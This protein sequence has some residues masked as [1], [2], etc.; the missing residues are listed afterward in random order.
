MNTLG[1]LPLQVSLVFLRKAAASR[2]LLPKEIH[3]AITFSSSR[4]TAPQ[5][6]IVVPFRACLKS[7]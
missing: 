2:L 1:N 3:V 7:Q 4:S 6:N 5:M